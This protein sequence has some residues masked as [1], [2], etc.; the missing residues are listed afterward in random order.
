MSGDRGAR[1][2]AAT[3]GR[4]RADA[5][6]PAPRRRQRPLEPLSDR[7]G[8]RRATGPGCCRPVPSRDRSSTP[9]CAPRHRS[10][11]TGRCRRN[12][13]PPLRRAPP[14]SSPAR[15]P[16]QG[17][18][19]S[20]GATTRHQPEKHRLCHQESRDSIGV[21]AVQPAGAPRIPRSSLGRMLATPDVDRS[22]VSGPIDAPLV[23]RS[24]V[25]VRDRIGD[26]E[27]YRRLPA[28]RFVVPLVLL[29]RRRFLLLGHVSFRC[30][31]G[32]VVNYD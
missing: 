9:R 4:R 28:D 18:V 2:A 3:H 14:N 20:C 23:G 8:L 26:V 6:W 11:A 19:R 5:A 27:R 24:L 16:E 17:S 12:A 22:L 32:A 30:K 25:L 29:F 15:R 7:R 13:A 31:V 10:G 1:S 21:F